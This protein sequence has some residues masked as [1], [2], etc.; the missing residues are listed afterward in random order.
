MLTIDTYLS[1][2]DKITYLEDILH[3]AKIG[4][5]AN[6]AVLTRDDEY[7]QDH[8]GT[9][10]S[11]P[12]QGCP[13]LLKDNI[14]LEGTI[15]TFGSKMGKNYRSPY[16]ATVSRK[17]ENAG[18]LIIGKTTMDEFA[19]WSTG[20]NSPYPLPHN[21]LDKNLVAWGSSSGAAV[22]VAS[23]FT[24]VALGT[25]TGGSVRMPAAF[26]GII[27]L[28]PTY[29]SISRYWVQAMASSF[30]QVWVFATNIKDTKIVFDIIKGQDS[31]DATTKDFKFKQIISTLVGMKIG[32]PKQYFGEGIDSDIKS[33]IESA[34]ERYKSQGAIIIELDIP[35]IDAGI[36]VYY[37]LVN[38]EV[39][40]NLARFDGLKFGLQHDTHESKNHMDYLAD[41]REQGF[42]DEVKRRILLWAHILSA[43]EYEGLY[44][45]AMN[46]RTEVTKQFIHHFKHDVDVIMGPTTPFLPWEIGKNNDDPVANYLAD[47]YTVIANITGMPALSIPAGFVEKENKKL[48]VWL[49]L[50]GNHAS[51]YNLFFIAD[52]FLKREW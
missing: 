5:K 40:S 43:S 30:D 36:S 29:G 17:L 31:Y 27:G 51:E 46:I 4:N 50:M 47:A 12:M 35:L 49:Q 37:T 42:G 32:I 2:S 45:K 14:L 52:Q 10:L 20:E 25:D 28:K 41:I 11:K 38:S 26:N 44:V 1:S 6:P 19:M 9:L 22:A 39:S 23:W 15:S 21:A 18:F 16:S 7:I 8:Q 48:P 34:I 33:T 3:Q 13:I 24:P